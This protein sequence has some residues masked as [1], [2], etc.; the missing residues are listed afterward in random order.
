MGIDL[1]QPEFMATCPRCERDIGGPYFDHREARARVKEHLA[2][3]H[4]GSGKP[5]WSL[6][7]AQRQRLREQRRTRPEDAGSFVW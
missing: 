2:N 5:D 7:W 1:G 6:T 3:V 4:Y